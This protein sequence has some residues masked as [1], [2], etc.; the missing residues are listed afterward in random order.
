LALLIRSPSIDEL[1]RLSDLCF[2]SKAVWGHDGTFMEACRHEL[3]FA[4]PDLEQTRIAVAEEDGRILGVVQVKIS[5]LDAD[6]LKLF[7]E[8]EALRNG[9]GS[10]LFAWAAAISKEMGA[11]RMVIEAD[12]DAVPFYR[13]MGARDAGQAPSGSIPGRML[14][15][16]TFDVLR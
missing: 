15:R 5:A 10:A 4:P 11:T 6:L 8:P 3:S 13:K 2:R 12:P 1:P 14:P 9:T 16:L 7:I